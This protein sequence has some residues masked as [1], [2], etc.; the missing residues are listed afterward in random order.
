MAESFSEAMATCG[1]LRSVKVL[2]SRPDRRRWYGHAIPISQVNRSVPVDIILGADGNIW[3]SN[4]FDGIG[5]MTPAGAVTFFSPSRET[6][7][8]TVL[9]AP[10]WLSSYQLIQQISSAPSLLRQINLPL[11]P[12]NMILGP[13]RNMWLAQPGSLEQITAHTERA[14][15][16]PLWNNNVRGVGD[17]ADGADRAIW[18]F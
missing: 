9:Q 3:F 6:I 8:Q 10:I 4:Q 11:Q 16:L 14:Y 18:F 13:D 5:Y 15:I 7:S 17:L 2:R 12:G 1:F